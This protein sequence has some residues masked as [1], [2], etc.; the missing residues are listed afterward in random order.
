MY[1]AF[2]LY[3]DM[4]RV[5]SN[6]PNNNQNPTAL[7]DPVQRI[8]AKYYMHIPSINLSNLPLSLSISLGINQQTCHI[9]KNSETPKPL[10]LHQ[11]TMQEG[12]WNSIGASLSSV[13]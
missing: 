8:S 1:L 10:P 9:N 5:R 6:Q 12:I 3:I 7:P 11:A 2:P 13:A 4:A